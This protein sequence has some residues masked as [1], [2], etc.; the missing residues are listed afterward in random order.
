M[1]RRTSAFF[2]VILVTASAQAYGPYTIKVITVG[3]GIS[4]AAEDISDSGIVVGNREWGGLKVPYFYTVEGG[5]E[6]PGPCDGNEATHLW[7]VNSSKLAVGFTWRLG[8]W[9]QGI[10]WTPRQGY[11]YLEPAVGFDGCVPCQVND[12]GWIVGYSYSKFTGQEQATLWRPTV[13]PVVLPTNNSIDSRALAVNNLG[14]IYGN[15]TTQSGHPYLARWTGTSGP[16]PLGPSKLPGQAVLYDIDD[17]GTI[18][19]YVRGGGSIYEPALWKRGEKPWFGPRPAASSYGIFIGLLGDGLV[20]GMADGN[21]YAN[22]YLWR[23]GSE[24][25]FLT[26]V[27]DFAGLAWIAPRISASNHR[28]MMAGYGHLLGIPTTFVLIPKER[29][30]RSVRGT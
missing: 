18:A 20:Y 3:Y 9:S 14:E 2:A 11:R 16:Y 15:Y 13:P 30:A 22:A 27:V 7:D 28:G 29:T 8:Q 21:G 23:P 26:N 12:K 6:W 4:D 1:N 25:E 5:V 10:T 17:T 24:A 19:G